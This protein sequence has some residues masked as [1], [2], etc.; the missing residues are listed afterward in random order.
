MHFA[1]QECVI[2]KEM[3][4]GLLVIWF[5]SPRLASDNVR[6]TES[7]RVNIIMQSND[8]FKIRHRLSLHASFNVIDEECAKWNMKKVKMYE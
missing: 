7:I 1:L 5:L 2:S 4:N 8:F 3:Q 6:R